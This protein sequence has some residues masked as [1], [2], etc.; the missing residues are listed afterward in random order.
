MIGEP[1]PWHPSC[2][3]KTTKPP[4]YISEG[5]K[6]G[7]RPAHIATREEGGHCEGDLI[8]GK[9]KS[10]RQRVVPADWLTVQSYD[11]SMN[12][13]ASTL[14]VGRTSCW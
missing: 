14:P 5:L 3:P 13:N 7:D 10:R 6:I 4:N 1:V 2:G 12:G 9:P 11:P 8:M